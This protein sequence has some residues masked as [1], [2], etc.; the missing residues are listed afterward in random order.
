MNETIHS[1]S[2]D[3]KHLSLRRFKKRPWG[4][5]GTQRFDSLTR[6][7]TAIFLTL[8]DLIQ[9][10][11][12]DCYY[13]H[14]SIAKRAHCARRT[15]VTALGRLKDLGYIDWV[16]RG[17]RMNPKTNKPMNLTNRYFLTEK[18]LHA[19]P[20]DVLTGELRD[21]EAEEKIRPVLQPLCVQKKR[22][23]PREYSKEY[24][25][26]SADAESQSASQILE[27]VGKNTVEGQRG[28]GGEGVDFGIS[29]PKLVL[30]RVKTREEIPL[31]GIRPSPDSRATPSRPV[32]PLLRDQAIH[33]IQAYRKHRAK[34]RSLPDDNMFFTHQY[35][36][37]G[38]LM[39]LVGG[40]ENA[41]RYLNFV[42][43]RWEDLIGST[44]SMDAEKL[45]AYPNLNQALAHWRIKIWWKRCTGD[46]SEKSAK[47]RAKAIQAR[48]RFKLQKQ[49][50]SEMVDQLRAMS[51]G[52]KQF[53]ATCF[54]F[55]LFGKV[56]P[57][58]EETLSVSSEEEAAIAAWISSKTVI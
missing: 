19:L 9:E 4:L 43:E 33:V 5:D 44:G 2:V 49:K 12:E 23:N 24:T 14:D 3:V 10:D 16:S 15:V 28:T 29:E 57:P 54:D 56:Q 11:L 47:K 38:T 35:E 22:R 30:S 50:L 42:T 31:R 20:Y 1:K 18:I 27:E 26:A 32:D 39:E 17:V 25:L 7:Q 6:T 46:T 40:R 51:T 13:S 52:V 41:V 34:Y 37:V 8:I 21:V 58:V 36:Q 55:T 53:D 48:E 45:L